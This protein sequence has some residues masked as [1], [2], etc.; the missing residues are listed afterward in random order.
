MEKIRI[1]VIGCGSRGC[2]VVWQL[3]SYAGDRAAVTAVFDP[4]ADAVTHAKAA[5]HTPE[6][7]VCGTAFELIGNSAVDL[8]MIFTPNAFHKENIIAAIRADK[9]VFSE[10]PLATTLDDCREILRVQEETGAQVITGFVL[11]YSPLYRKVKELLD[12]GTFGRILNINAT[13]NRPSWG[14]GHSM[15]SC[16]GWRRSTALSGPYLL[17]KC[18]H[19][20][21]LL[22]WFAGSL[23][24]RVAGFGGLD[25]FVPENKGLLDKYGFETYGKMV[26][27]EKRINPFTSPK[28]IKDNHALV[29]E[30]PNGI[31]MT[32]QLTLANAIPE[33]RMYISC[34]GGTI[35]L[36]LFSGGLSYRRYNEDYVTKLEFAGDGHGGGDE[37]MVREIVDSL[38]CGG[39]GDR[40]SGVR[41][42]LD[43][44][45]V[46]LAAD[47]AM[48]EGR[49]VNLSEMLIPC[50]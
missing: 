26:P 4:S 37:V 14:G 49:V 28:D 24:I 34:T 39:S 29:M 41:N 7:E 8:V 15:S 2:G 12:S 48:N 50:V 33:R 43:C 22:N 32:F 27:P 25:L 9:L 17:E 40:V 18:S 3:L 31:K 16:D 19:D 5:W 35:S 13:E 20:L 46:A 36:E 11:R 42:G 45:L 6:L 10:K 47:K 1:G 44:A 30:Y 21:D 23:P 38:L